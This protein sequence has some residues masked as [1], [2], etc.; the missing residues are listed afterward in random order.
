M[1]LTRRD[2]LIAGSAGVV[3]V[4]L[5]SPR[6]ARANDEALDLVKQLTGR[7]ATRSDRLRLIMP[8]EFPTG[9][10]VPMSLDID[11]PMT[12]ADHVRQIRVFAPQNPI[13]EVASFQF[14]PQR[15]LPR[16][17]TRIRLAKPQHVVAVAEMS[18]GVLLMTTTW[19]RVATDGCA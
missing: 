10:T 1:S 3:G 12:E 15:S 16:V 4:A 6:S 18:D 13:I 7:T 8:A 5:F 2:V 19:V 17:S 11:S 14:V 9:Y